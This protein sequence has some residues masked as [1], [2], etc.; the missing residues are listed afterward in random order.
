MISNLRKLAIGT[1]VAMSALLVSATDL[2]PDL[3]AAKPVAQGQCKLGERVYMCIL[4]ELDSNFYIAVVDNAGVL[5]VF[6]VKES[7]KDHPDIK[8]EDLEV[9]YQRPNEKTRRRTDV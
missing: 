8:D 3:A 2:F 9:I 5:V 4:V 6:Q 7:A 1:A